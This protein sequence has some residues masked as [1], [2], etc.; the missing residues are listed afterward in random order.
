MIF[1]YHNKSKFTW[2]VLLLATAGLFFISPGKA[3]ATL[4]SYITSIEYVEITLSEGTATASANLSSSQTTANCVPFVTMYFTAGASADAFDRKEAD[5]Y[6]E[7]GP[8]VTATRENTNGQINLGIYVVEFNPTYVSVQ[9]GT[10]SMA[11]TSDTAA[12]TPVDQ[13]KAAM[14]HYYQFISGNDKF[15]ETAVAGWFSSNSQLTFQRDTSFETISGHYYVFE[16]L[17]SE[18]SVQAKTFS[19]LANGTSATTSLTSVAM[20]KTFLIASYR[21]GYNSSNPVFLTSVLHKKGRGEL[22]EFIQETLR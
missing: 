13:S 10:F 5:I 20:D 15:D 1:Q 3:E 2:L 21:L 12:I 6:F 22:L 7:S 14:V 9:Q 19:I 18:F 17:N 8:K 11:G 16:A 4:A